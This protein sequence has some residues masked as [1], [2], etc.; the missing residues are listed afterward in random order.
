MYKTS[1]RLPFNAKKIDLDY[2]RTE[3]PKNTWKRKLRRFAYKYFVFKDRTLE[4]QKKYGKFRVV[5]TDCGQVTQ[6]MDY[7]TARF[8]RDKFIGVIIDNF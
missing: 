5:Y 6:P 2:E 4:E 1:E 7:A 3:P 8:Y